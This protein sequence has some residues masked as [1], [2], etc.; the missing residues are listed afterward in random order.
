MSH[1]CLSLI[2][3]QL[4]FVKSHR[5]TPKIP[6]TFALNLPYLFVIISTFHFFTFSLFSRFTVVGTCTSLWKFK[7]HESLVQRSLLVQCT[8]LPRYTNKWR[9]YVS[10]VMQLLQVSS[11]PRTMKKAC[12]SFLSY[13][14]CRA[15]AVVHRCW[16]VP[17]RGVLDLPGWSRR[18]EE[19]LK[20]A[21]LFAQ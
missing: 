18:K 1:S 4:T 14:D 12:R 10:K 7:I 5:S 11:N 8:S 16:L 2:L 15:R 3:I 13:P 17:L 6:G 20:R 21:A 19:I 9:C